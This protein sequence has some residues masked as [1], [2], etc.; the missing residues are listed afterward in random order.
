MQRY[1]GLARKY[2]LAVSG[3]SD[4]HGEVKPQ[5]SLGTG[6]RGNLDIPKSVLDGLRA[7]AA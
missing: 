4:F 7:V 6:L 1:A 5:I 2:D 3:G